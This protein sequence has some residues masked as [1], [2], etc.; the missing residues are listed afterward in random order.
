MVWGFEMDTGLVGRVNEGGEVAGLF[1]TLLS[2][3]M[4]GI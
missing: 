1:A 2:R 3:N 4:R